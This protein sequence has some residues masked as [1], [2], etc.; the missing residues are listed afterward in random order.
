MPSKY[1]DLEHDTHADNKS[2]PVPAGTSS[3]IY[4]EYDP[5]TDRNLT[6]S[7]R[8]S[9]VS[10]QRMLAAR[11]PEKLYVDPVPGEEHLTMDNPAIYSGH[12]E[13]YD[14]IFDERT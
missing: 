11:Y 4:P 13:Y 12:D 2:A 1:D 14:V 9:L 3:P 6:P 8:E 10:R 5:A 7:E